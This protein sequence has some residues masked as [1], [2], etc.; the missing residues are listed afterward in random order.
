SRILPRRLA[1]LYPA[2]PDAGEHP[3]WRRISLGVVSFF[4]VII[5]LIQVVS[6]FGALPSWSAPALAVYRWIAPFRSINSYGLFAVMTPD[7]PEIIVEGSNDGRE[8]KEYSFP[9]KPG[10]LNRRPTFVAPHQ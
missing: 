2:P 1:N 8:W 3:L 6:S 5:S 4:F 10:A 9:H 7:R